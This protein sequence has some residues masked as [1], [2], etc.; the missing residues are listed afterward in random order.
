MIDVEL[1]LDW[2]AVSADAF[3]GAKAEAGTSQPPSEDEGTNEGA[4]GGQSAAGGGEAERDADDAQDQSVDSD[5][6]DE[7][8]LAIKEVRCLGQKGGGLET[9]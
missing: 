2:D 5:A 1:E 4:G 7:D 8:S 9:E 3:R 6:Q